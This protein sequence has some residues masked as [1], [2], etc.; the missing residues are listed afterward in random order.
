[1]KTS[2]NDAN[3]MLAKVTAFPFGAGRRCAYGAGLFLLLPGL[4]ACSYRASDKAALH[5]KTVAS[6]S[7]AMAV[8]K[9]QVS[10]SRESNISLDMQAARTPPSTYAAHASASVGARMMLG[11]RSSNEI[12]SS[13]KRVV[14]DA[15][16]TLRLL[17]TA[18]IPLS[19]SA[20]GVNTGGESMSIVGAVGEKSGFNGLWSLGALALIAIVGAGL[21]HYLRKRSDTQNGGHGLATVK[22]APIPLQDHVE[23]FED[24]TR[25]PPESVSPAATTDV[26]P[27]RLTFSSLEWS[28]QA[29]GYERNEHWD[30]SAPVDFLPAS[31]SAYVSPIVHAM[32]E[33]F[34][35]A[36]AEEYTQILE[37]GAETSVTVSEGGRFSDLFNQL[38][39][40]ATRGGEAI[41]ALLIERDSSLPDVIRTSREPVPS[42][43]LA[44]W[45]RSL[46]KAMPDANTLTLPWL[47]ISTL[48]LQADEAD[49]HETESLYEEAEKWVDLSMASD[50]ER[51]A[52]WLAR[53]IDIDLRRTRRQKGAARLLSLRSMQSRYAQALARGEP[54]LLFAWVDVLI[55]WAECQFGNAALARYAEAEAMCIRL[56][57]LP[58][59]ADIAQR[60]RA[61]ILRQRATIEEGGARLKSLDTAQTLLDLLYERVPSGNNALAVAV[62]ALARGNVL[63]SEQAKEAYS[64]ALTHAFMAEGAP[65]L[66]AEGLQCRLAVQW[67]YENL[68]GMPVQSDVA[69]GLASRLEAL[70]VQHPD[71]VQCMAQVYL[72]HADFAHATALCEKAWRNGRATPALL[73]TWQEA[74]RRWASA[75]TQPEQLMA[76]Q[77]AM[78]QLSIANAMR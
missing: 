70:H 22:T 38:E 54:P 14:G 31:M 73:A 15:S 61:E 3:R 39:A 67:A 8:A 45:E 29:P 32:S 10:L 18:D 44:A 48:L 43:I 50:I 5:A 51:S 76:Q 30:M 28:C 6:E 1:M 36:M 35:E 7:Y 24:A 23:L 47:L 11:E 12:A 27:M 49:Q 52:A 63:P 19:V 77:Q 56:C 75:S 58:D 2:E 16:V 25:V 9:P 41:P 60:R 20:V 40:I 21:V 13:L 64:H 17:S 72:R 55:F 62:T 59:S 46:R 65:H 68:P 74:C 4:A 37:E 78:R 69:I 57:E 42:A 53:H 34:S 71:T 26:E 33:L 66:R